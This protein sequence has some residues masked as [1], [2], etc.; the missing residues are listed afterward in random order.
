MAG[1]GFLFAGPRN[2]AKGREE[3][4]GD[5]GAGARRG[6]DKGR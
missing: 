5:V 1:Q 6:D 4:Q 3:G 2:V